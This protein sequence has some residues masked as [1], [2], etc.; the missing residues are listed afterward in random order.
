VT[1]LVLCEVRNGVAVVTL[2]RPDRGNSWTG[3]MEVEY[4]ARLAE[5]EADG[6]VRVIVIT[7]AGRQFCVGADAAALDGMTGGGGYDDGVREPLAQPGRSDDPDLGGRHAFLWAI[8]KPVIAAMNGAAAGLGLA[9]AC[10]C[11]LRFAAARAKFTTATARLGLPAEFG[12]SWLLPRM[13]G[14]TRAADLLLSGRVILADE[15]ERIGLV[16]GVFPDDDV[17]AE[18][19]AYAERLARHCAPSSLRAIKEQLYRDLRGTLAEAEADSRRRLEEMTGSADFLE[20][21]AAL[22]GRRDPDFR[23]ADASSPQVDDPGQG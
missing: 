22:V 21:V 19:V 5:A 11:D 9:I 2:N 16:N 10:Y 15:A 13:L 12:L 23:P 7:G 20:G 8:P 4:R 17:L 1:G 14:T 18:T 3:R 6:S